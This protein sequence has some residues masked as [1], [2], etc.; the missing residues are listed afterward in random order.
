MRPPR[1]QVVNIQRSCVQPS[2]RYPRLL[3]KFSISSKFTK[4]LARVGRYATA[5]T[6][7]S[8]AGASQRERLFERVRAGAERGA[9]GRRRALLLISRDDQ[10]TGESDETGEHEERGGQ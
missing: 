9:A 4:P 5:V 6:S 8:T 7:T 1:F 2:P 3:M 10:G